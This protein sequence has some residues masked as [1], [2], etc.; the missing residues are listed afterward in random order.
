MP[1]ILNIIG[2]RPEILKMAPVVKALQT[3]P[4]FD[5]TV[6]LTAQHRELLDQMGRL[7]E[8]PISHDLDIMQP[9]QSLSTLSARLLNK[10][11]GIFNSEQPDMVIAQGDTTTTFISALAC[12]YSKIPFGYV[13]SGLRSGDFY[14]PFPEEMNRQFAAKMAALN[15]APTELSK[16]N[17]LN[18][19]IDPKSIFVTGNTVID[20]L[21]EFANKQSVAPIHSNHRTILV[22]CHRR[23]NFGQPLLNICAAIKQ[24][25]EKHEDVEIIYPV[26]P[27][28]NVQKPVYELLQHERIHLLEPLSY[29]ELVAQMKNAYFVLTDSG[30]LQEE[31]P[32]LNKPVL[33]MRTETERPEGIHAG[34]AKLVGVDTDTIVNQV[35]EL[36]LNEHA[37]DAMTDAGSPFGDGKASERIAKHVAAY[38]VRSRQQAELI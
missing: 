15:F 9:N 37:Y 7:F 13:E 22:T 33:I 10:L 2:T 21:L 30:G 36:L 23:E 20:T 14:S 19:G 3:N 25:I 29:P 8:L 6:A 32:A 31:A 18:E 17:L 28:P 34:A 11:S 38:F 16:N 12:F 26:H 1:R 5:V 27:N 24:I 35:N 4:Q